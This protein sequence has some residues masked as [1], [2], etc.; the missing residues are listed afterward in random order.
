M[1]DLFRNSKYKID[2]N[3]NSVAYYSQRV[4]S[5]S[6][7]LDVGGQNA[8]SITRRIIKK[9]CKNQT[10]KIICTDIDVKYK[11]DIVDDICKSSLKNNSFEGIFCYAVLEHVIDYQSAVNN[12]YNILSKNGEAIFLVP[13][14][15][16]YHDKI[17]YGRF[18][19]T[20]LIKLLDIFPEVKLFIP[21]KKGFGGVLW[22]VLTYYKIDK[23]PQMHSLLSKITNMIL[24]VFLIFAF[25]FKNRAYNCHISFREYSFYYIYL[26]INNCLC[27][28]A[29]K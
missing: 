14:F 24:R 1:L 29:K 17:D 25:L 21:N 18:T 19:F 9:Y 22:S 15:W 16:H 8:N 4:A 10:T 23:L 13:F 20:G 12:I 28:W 11:P 5:K 2:F 6:I 26:N 27:A 3:T 7:I